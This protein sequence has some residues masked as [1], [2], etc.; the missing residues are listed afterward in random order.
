MGGKTKHKKE[1]EIPKASRLSAPPSAGLRRLRFEGMPQ[2]LTEDLLERHLR[3][4]LHVNGVPRPPREIV[5]AI[6][7]ITARP[8][9]YAF[10]DFDDSESCEQALQLNG[11]PFW[12]SAPGA[13]RIFLENIV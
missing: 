3:S 5:V 4:F 13:V 12:D 6:D 1:E 7:P 8:K 2:Q 9:G 10:L 11:E